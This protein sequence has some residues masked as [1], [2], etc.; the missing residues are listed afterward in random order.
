MADTFRCLPFRKLC[1]W[2]GHSSQ[3]AR[4]GCGPLN[5]RVL[6]QLSWCI[7]L[8]IVFS[9]SVNK[10]SI[11]NTGK[12]TFQWGFRAYLSSLEA[13]GNSLFF[14]RSVR[15]IIATN[16]PLS[17]TMGSL[18]GG[19]KRLFLIY[20]YLQGIAIAAHVTALAKLIQQNL[21]LWEPLI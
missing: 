20:R 4:G 18:P 6:F 7:N 11:Y 5:K 12:P 21:I 15:A 14:L 19:K 9:D 1:K 10:L 2:H 16:S 17:F 3:L 13:R 8:H